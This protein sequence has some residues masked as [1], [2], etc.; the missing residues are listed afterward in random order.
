MYLKYIFL[1]PK[2]FMQKKFNFK[3]IQLKHKIIK[4]VIIIVL[5]LDPIV[6]PEQDPI[7]D[8]ESQPRLISI[9]L[10]GSK[11]YYFNKIIFQR[12]VNEFFTR[13]LLWIDRVVDRLSF[14][15]S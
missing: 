8:W 3:I 5:K 2:I 1:I 6:N 9:F 10:K 14:L 4:I 12:K 11:Q 13:V 15:L 7:T